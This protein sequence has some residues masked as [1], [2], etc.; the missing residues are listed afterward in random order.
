MSQAHPTFMMALQVIIRQVDPHDERSKAR[1]NSS[2]ELYRHLKASENGMVSGEL[3][4]PT[5]QLEWTH[6]EH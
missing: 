1:L 2:V 4:I 3:P 5:A 6:V